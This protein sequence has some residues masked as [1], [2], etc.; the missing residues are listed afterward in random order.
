M[1]DQRFDKILRNNLES[2]RPPYQPA[3]WDRFSKRLPE[4]GMWPWLKQFGGWA[5]CGMMLAGWGTTLF[6]LKENQALIR[7]LTG[8]MSSLS[9][10]NPSA[11][12]TPSPEISSR[13][14]V[15][16]TD[17]VYLVRKTIVEHQYVNAPKG[18]SPEHVNM[19]SPYFEEIKSGKANGHAV[20]ASSS[21]SNDTKNG[22]GNMQP[23]T[24]YGLPDYQSAQAVHD[25][26]VSDT[27]KSAASTTSV[28]PT[29][30]IAIQNAFQYK[31]IKSL[32]DSI[33]ER[34]SSHPQEPV[35]TPI[36]RTPFHLS[37]LQPRF[38]IESHV[39]LHSYG[40]GASVELFPT[41]N[42]GISVGIRASKLEAENHKALRDYNSATGKLF[43]VQYS[44]YLPSRFDRIE[45]ISIKTTVVGL[46]LNLKYYIPVKNNLSLFI[47]SGTTLDLSAYQQVNFESYLNRS[48]RRN[49][50]ETGASAHFFHNFM[51][52]AGVQY[53]S[54]RISAQISPNYIYDFRNIENTPSGGNL[55][56]KGAL[57]INLFQ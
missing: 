9:Q 32:L 20:Q 57:W 5:L 36:T 14:A 17:T 21:W 49:T 53:Q 6:T 11:V 55:G 24:S 8:Q 22:A 48:K 52:G 26:M 42:L 16:K 25:G 51:F 13:Q 50:F 39:A 34:R 23:K 15:Y 35:V 38:G 31:S 3:A 46:P 7:Q 47:H 27:V 44:S 18:N 19:G 43:V 41:E 12:T 37:A 56:L 54:G 40:F 30:S 45:D 28:L 4:R 33:S 10:T 29:D 1:S 2:V